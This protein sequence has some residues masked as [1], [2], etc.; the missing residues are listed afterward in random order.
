MNNVIN[1]VEFKRIFV[2]GK[3]MRLLDRPKAVNNER[4][5]EYF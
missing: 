5:I 2:S 1:M 4:K 3:G